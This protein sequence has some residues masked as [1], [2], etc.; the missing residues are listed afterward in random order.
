MIAGRA[1]QGEAS[2][3]ELLPGVSVAAGP[4]GRRPMGAGKGRPRLPPDRGR[5]EALLLVDPRLGPPPPDF[6]EAVDTTSVARQL[7]GVCVL[8]WQYQPF[9]ESARHVHE[10]SFMKNRGPTRERGDP[11]GYVHYEVSSCCRLQRFREVPAGKDLYDLGDVTDFLEGVMG[12]PVVPTGRSLQDECPRAP[13]ARMRLP[14]LSFQVL[15]QLFTATLPAICMSVPLTM[16]TATH[17]LLPGFPKPWMIARWRRV[18]GVRRQRGATVRRAPGAAV[19]DHADIV[20]ELPRV[21][22]GAQGAV[23]AGAVSH[24][25]KQ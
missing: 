19:R 16:R 18:C 4:G 15:L 1:R 8:E 10:S 22:P 9:S 14:V 25:K 17:M 2:E 3:D 7:A 12:E 6:S 24:A 21:R 5:F 13:Y 23:G 11:W 20:L